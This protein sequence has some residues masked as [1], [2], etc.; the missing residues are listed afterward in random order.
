MFHTLDIY[1]RL[2]GVQLRSQMQYRASFLFDIFTTCLVVFFEFGS[3]ALVFARFEH[4]Q[5]WTLG[6]VAFI[7][8]LVEVSFGLMEFFFTGFDPQDFGQAMRRGT[9]D[10]LLL[11]P[12]NI[13]AQV[14]GSALALR[15]VGNRHDHVL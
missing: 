13:T 1:R 7:Y 6:E 8:G 12:I 2:I 11:R 4:I 5:G 9:F 3:L 14:L 10:Q 15:R